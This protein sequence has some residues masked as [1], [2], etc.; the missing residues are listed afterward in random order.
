MND[1]RWAAALAALLATAGLVL[2]FGLYGTSTARAVDCTR[3]PNHPSCH[4]TPTPTPTP[5]PTPTTPTPTPT[6]TPTTTEPPGVRDPL[7]QPFDSGSIWNMPIGSGAVYVPAELSGQPRGDVWAPMPMSD[8]EHIVLTPTAPLT[9]VRYS[10][11]GWG[12]NRCST[13]GAPLFSA[14]IPSGYVVPSS[15]RNDSAAFL[16]PDG[17]TIKQS[18]PLARCVAGSYAT[19]LVSFPD[20]DI[21]GTGITGAHGGSGLSAIGGSLR[22]GEL[23][24]GSTEGPRHAL[25]VLV[26]AAFELHSCTVRADCMRWPATKAD[27][28]AVGTYGSLDGGNQPTAMKMGALLAL[29]TSVNIDA[30]GLE[31][32]PGRQIAWTLQNYGAYI[33]DDT[34]NGGFGFATEDSP[35]GQFTA[36]FQADYGTPFE[37]RA[38]SGTAWMRDVQ[39]IVTRLAVVDNNGPSSIGGGGTPLQPLAPSLGG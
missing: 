36:Q 5:S 37:A 26:E 21:Y 12:G 33:V 31:T 28:Y 9:E 8:F 38:N 4:P 1:R 30:I 29:P 13:N 18:Q 22:V 20:V 34:Y 27:S 19:S 2:P 3:K 7:V 32:V 39:R 35:A 15:N 17:R 11:A 6:P 24:P 14:P 16:M 10:S 23:R 25:K